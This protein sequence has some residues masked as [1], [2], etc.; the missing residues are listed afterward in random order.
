MSPADGPRDRE[1]REQPERGHDAPHAATEVATRVGTAA[2]DAHG[3]HIGTADEVAGQREEHV[4]PGVEMTAD[5]AHERAER[6]AHEVSRRHA[7]GG[8]PAGGKRRAYR[9]W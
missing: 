5:R 8:R 2:P 9:T 3:P 7:P 6:A 1:R 4:H